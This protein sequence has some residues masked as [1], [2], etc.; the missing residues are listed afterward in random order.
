MTRQ[1]IHI[2]LTIFSTILL[3]ACGQKGNKENDI[4]NSQVLEPSGKLIQIDFRDNNYMDLQPSAKDTITNDGWNVRYL[5][6]DDSTKYN[7]IYIECSKGNVS[8]LF[9]GEN[10]LQYR[11]YFIPTFIGECTQ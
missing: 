7:D 9:H 2:I 10:L 8:G 4:S 6:K 3:V 11:H 1:T 5:I